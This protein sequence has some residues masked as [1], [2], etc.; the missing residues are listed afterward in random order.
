MGA[1]THQERASSRPLERQ[2]RRRGSPLARRGGRLAEGPLEPQPSPG[3]G[4]VPARAAARTCRLVNAASRRLFRMWYSWASSG[5][6]SFAWTCCGLRFAWPSGFGVQPLAPEGCGW[7]RRSTGAA[8]PWRLHHRPEAARRRRRR[9]AMHPPPPRG[10]RRQQGCGLQEMHPL[11]RSPRWP[12]RSGRWG[13]PAARR[14]ALLRAARLGLQPWGRCPWWPSCA[15]LGKTLLNFGCE[16]D[17]RGPGQ[18]AAVSRRHVAVPA[19]AAA[20][21]GVKPH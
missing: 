21:D 2:A 14:A 9:V 11:P 16:R 10:R 4:R 12:K 20:S 15:L 6:E 13:L 18:Q 19:G 8:L 7:G 1:A 3:N 5:I 17:W